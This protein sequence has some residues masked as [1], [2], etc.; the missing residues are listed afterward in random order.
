[1]GTVADYLSTMY[2]EVRDKLQEMYD[3]I[4]NLAVGMV[5]NRIKGT[6][7]S[8]RD[9]RIPLEVEPGISYRAFDPD[10]GALGRN[11]NAKTV[12]QLI[13]TF[14][15]LSG[16]EITLKQIRATQGRKQAVASALTKLLKNAVYEAKHFDDCSFHSSPDGNAQG[17]IG[18]AT[19]HS[20]AS[21]TS[22][23][24]F[25]DNA[26]NGSHGLGVNLMRR[27][28]KAHVFS[29]NL[30]TFRTSAAAIKITAVDKNAKTITFA[31]TIAGGANDDKILFDGV[32]STP[33]WKYGMFY[34]NSN[35]TTGNLLSLSRSANP[36]IVA[37]SVDAGGSLLIP[38]HAMLLSDK[39]LQARGTSDRTYKGFS[40]M[41]QRNRVRELQ[42]SVSELAIGKTQDMVNLV[43][44]G[45]TEFAFGDFTFSIDLHMPRTRLDV[46]V[47]ANWGK[48]SLGNAGIDFLLDQNGNK[49]NT[50]MATAD[51][52]PTTAYDFYLDQHENVFSA[53]AGSQGFIY[54]LAVPASA[55]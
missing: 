10:G 7:V 55:N 8:S 38:A 30:G 26:A 3:V 53:D 39:I 50:I 5:M 22:V 18:Y 36:E 43:P 19:A 13:S 46:L 6:V 2:E 48:I 44:T 35:L 15:T 16:G 41:A 20:A 11:D 51:G 42:I 27:G 34:F 1:M 23:Y 31:S 49:F 37:Q 54:G 14:S 12:H 9:M 17:V 32:T 29:N 21:G 4:P 40:H 33:A 45:K 25:A 52:S 47:P 24:T 28:M